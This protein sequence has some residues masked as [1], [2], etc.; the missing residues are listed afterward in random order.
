MVSY[1]GVGREFGLGPVGRQR[2]PV[3][4]IAGGW[5]LLVLKNAPPPQTKKGPPQFTRMLK[6]VH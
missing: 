2:K 4:A 6:K 3:K 5:G 1:S